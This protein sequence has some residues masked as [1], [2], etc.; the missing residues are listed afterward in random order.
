MSPYS[1]LPSF[2]NVRGV[3]AG[4]WR[5]RCQQNGSACQFPGRSV[6][7]KLSWNGSRGRGLWHPEGAPTP[8]SV[9]FREGSWALSTRGS[10][11]GS[12][13]LFLPLL[14]P[15]R[16]SNQRPRAVLG[17]S[18]LPSP[19][20]HRGSEIQPI[21]ASIPL[22]WTPTTCCWLPHPPCPTII[23][24]ELFKMSLGSNHSSA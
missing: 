15:P 12:F 10:K 14:H 20:G 18:D 23:L 16:H 5:R 4:H 11:T 7:D 19:P 17:L 3:S 9:G 2:K 1:V 13:S 8:G 21:P 24:S 22:P 6:A